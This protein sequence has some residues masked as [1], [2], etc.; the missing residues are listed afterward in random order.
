MK[1]FKSKNLQEIID[2]IFSIAWYDFWYKFI[3]KNQVIEWEN[4]YQ[5]YTRTQEQENEFETW[6]WVYMQDYA[7]KFKVEKEV[8]YF[9]LSYWLRV[10]N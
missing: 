4:W 9:I 5:Y 2:K 10:V 3:E 8:W 7:Y 1:K 6:L